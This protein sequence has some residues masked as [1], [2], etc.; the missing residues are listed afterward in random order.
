MSV[1]HDDQALKNPGRRHFLRVGIAGTAILATAGITAGVVGFKRVS[2][3]EVATGYY[4]FRPDDVA[5]LTALV[6]VILKGSL[7]EDTSQHPAIIDAI[8]K[9]MDDTCMR[10]G[11]PNQKELSQLFDLLNF[12]PSRRL[13]AGVK[14]PW[15]ELADEDIEA[16]LQRWRHSSVGL[17]NAAYRVLTK[18]ASN[19]YFAMPVSFAISGYPGPLE[20][21]YNAIN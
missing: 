5:L 17:F 7:P 13:A 15:A 21:M 9:S 8:I 1:S 4:L 12:A 18:L 3:Q 20:H 6:P 14:K 2:N 10:L 19:A 11:P 16:F